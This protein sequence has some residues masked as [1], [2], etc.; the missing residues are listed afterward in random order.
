MKRIG[1]IG[2]GWIFQSEH[3]LGYLATNNGYIHGFCD[4]NTELA[5]KA[6]KIYVDGIQQRLAK[7]TT[8]SEKELC[9]KALE[10]K[11]YTKAEEMIPN[12]DGVDICTPPQF[13][14][15]FAKM[16][17]DAGKAVLCEKPLARTYLDAEFALDSLKKVPFYI[18]TQVIYNPIFKKGK[19]IIESG[20]I[21]EIVR[22]KDCH[23]TLDLDHTV[24]KENFWLPLVSGGGALKDIGPHAYSVMRYWLGKNYRLK[25]VKDNGIATR[26]AER[27]IEN[28][29]N[30]KVRVED[31]AKLQI[32][33]ENDQGKI[34]PAE[35]EAYW[36]GQ[37]DYCKYGLYHEIEGTKGTMIFPNG[38]LGLLLGKKP[39]FGIHVFFKIIYKDGRVEKISM[40]Q[41]AP[42][43]ESKVAI[44]EFCAGIDSRS[45]AWYGEDM[46]LILD[47]GY[48]SKKRGGQKITPADFKAYCK[49]IGGTD[50]EAPVKVINDLFS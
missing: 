19:E 13:H 8:S 36:G 20:K 34:I 10:C 3:V 12:V 4:L 14:M 47:G 16:A 2:C 9:T 1:I 15:K 28:K 49:Q 6:K 31:V 21:G 50:K 18:F 48:L 29:P 11:T 40:P 23:A 46:M 37:P 41:P 25:T 38:T 45:P 43:T 32:E 26:V 33:W 44:D 42:H 22:I 5:E 39:F 35:L 30:Y 27:T 24:S 7:A 17:A